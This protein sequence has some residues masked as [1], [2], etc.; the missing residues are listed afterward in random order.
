MKIIAIEEHFTT[1]EYLNYLHSRKAPPRREYFEDKN[2]RQLEQDEWLPGHY[3][4]V[5]AAQTAQLLDIGE[6]RLQ[7]MAESGIDMQVL[8]LSF[9]GTELFEAPDATRVA[10][11]AND[12][13][14]S[15]IRKHPD[16]FAGWAA[17]APQNPEAAADELERAVQ[18]LGLKGA[19]INSHVRGEYLDEKK[20][21]TIFERAE[22][23][24][25]PIYL[26]PQ[27]PS[28]DMIKP[29]LAYPGLA[30]AMLG[31]TA[32]AGLHAMRL[33]CSGIFDR[34]PRLK[35]ILGHL[36][37]ALPFL[38][39]RIDNVF[40][41]YPL[42]QQLRKTPSQYLKDNFFITTSGNFWPAALQFVC[43]EL[44]ADRVL[45]AVDY[46]YEP[47]RPAVQFLESTPLSD[48]DR[49]KI[50]HRNAERLLSL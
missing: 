43:S 30:L 35:I 16:K 24:D 34:Y 15:Q 22:S 26:H 42:S 29:Y 31:F 1:Q 27:P 23:L 28:P 39:W 9:P 18:E 50:C 44:G 38:L 46:P 14:A 47:S 33:I 36:G 41:R 21:W 37:E 10:R 17:L 25:V 13:L 40:R 45:F 19:L 6:G 12:E 7:N 11:Q 32:E 49:E 8:S 20:F 4:P 3:R 48:D 2:H 5:N